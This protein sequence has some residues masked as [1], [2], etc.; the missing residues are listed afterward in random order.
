MDNNNIVDSSLN[1]FLSSLIDSKNNQTKEDILLGKIIFPP[2]NSTLE[3]IDSFQTK[4]NRIIKN[5]LLKEYKLN[6]YD[7]ERKKLKKNILNYEIQLKNLKQLNK[8]INL[9]LNIKEQNRLKS[10]YTSNQNNIDKNNNKIT[11]INSLTRESSNYHNKKNYEV[12]KSIS[13]NKYE[14]NNKSISSP[15]NIVVKKNIPKNIFIKPL[16]SSFKRDF[17]RINNED[18]EQKLEDE[19]K[20]FIRRINGVKSNQRTLKIN[21]NKSDYY[22]KIEEEM[23]L[24]YEK[25]EKEKEDYNKYLNSN[26]YKEEKKN[27]FGYFEG[28]PI[29]N[30]KY[31]YYSSR[32]KNRNKFN[33][34]GNNII[35]NQLKNYEENTSNLL[36]D[37]PNINQYKYLNIET[38]KSE[39][40]K[41][42]DKN[43]SE[44]IIDENNFYKIQYDFDNDSPSFSDINVRRS[45]YYFNDPKYNLSIEKKLEEFREKDKIK[46]KTY[47]SKFDDN[48]SNNTS[49]SHIKHNNDLSENNINENE[50]NDNNFNLNDNLDDD[51]SNLNDKGEIINQNDKEEDNNNFDV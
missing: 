21:K 35:R 44:N 23:K 15:K 18:K 1:N 34:Y 26:E 3:N 37:I 4:E 50:I 27:K 5:N 2:Y 12:I 16:I 17:S 14:I 13:T 49:I 6:L 39:Q 48:K 24:Y 9:K 47:K 7:E 42:N 22:K 41:T 20:A 30:K 33:N 25:K 28:K 43:K 11:Q 51:D 36:N 38:N 8:D 40:L 10:A 31:H 46:R 45:P 29:I 32:G 19:A